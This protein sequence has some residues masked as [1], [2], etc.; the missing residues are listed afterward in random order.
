M[1]VLPCFAVFMSSFTIMAIAVDRHR[2]ICR[3][4]Y[5]QVRKETWMRIEVLESFY[6]LILK[7]YLFASY[8][9]V[10]VQKKN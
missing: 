9:C 7:T 5:R 1:K 10:H 3:P 8:F 2:M 4:T 6:L